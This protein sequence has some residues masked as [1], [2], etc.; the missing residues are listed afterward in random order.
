MAKQSEST[1]KKLSLSAKVRLASE[2]KG[3][4]RFNLRQF[5]S[6]KVAHI[7]VCQKLV[8]LSDKNDGYPIGNLVYFAVGKNAHRTHVYEDGYKTIDEKKAK[9]ILS[10]LK[11]FAKH[12]GNPKLMRNAD[13]AHLLCHYYDKV[14]KNTEDF[15]K[16]LEAYAPCDKVENY[17]SLA[18]AM[19]IA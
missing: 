8:E 14:S 10:W 15:K 11:L 13:V 9:T 2:G 17:K 19:H 4:T 18:T 7:E 5:A 1:E 16:V 6:K 12:N 3:L